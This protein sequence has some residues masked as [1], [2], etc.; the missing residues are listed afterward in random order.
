ML[1]HNVVGITALHALTVGHFGDYVNLVFF[2]K[3]LPISLMLS[4]IVSTSTQVRIHIWNHD[5]KSPLKNPHIVFLCLPPPIALRI[6]YS[7]LNLWNSC[8]SQNYRSI[9]HRMACKTTSKYHSHSIQSAV[10]LAYYSHDDTLRVGGYIG[11]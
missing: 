10:Q 11:S 1:A 5:I 6:T 3:L 7:S 4:A 9:Q 2:P 8:N